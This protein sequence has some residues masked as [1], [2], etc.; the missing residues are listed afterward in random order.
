MINEI[1]FMLFTPKQ[2]TSLQ[3][4]HI[5]HFIPYFIKVLDWN[6]S[7]WRFNK[8]EQTKNV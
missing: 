3:A 2:T 6:T 4:S 8:K 1:I 5:S 7:N